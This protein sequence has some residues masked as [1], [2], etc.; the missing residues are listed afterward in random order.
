[1]SDILHGLRDL[2]SSVKGF[3]FFS[4]V[5]GTILF[6]LLFRNDISLII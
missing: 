1:M 4:V 5:G 2:L 3:I 6:H